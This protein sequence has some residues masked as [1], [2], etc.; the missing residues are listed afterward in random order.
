M[1]KYQHIL[2]LIFLGAKAIIKRVSIV[3]VA[4]ECPEGKLVC[5]ESFSP[6]ITKL[7]LSKNAAGLGMAN[8]F[9]R[10]FEKIAE[11]IRDVNNDCQNL[12]Q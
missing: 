4:I 9:F 11:K 2:K 8:N 3:N 1:K 7:E 5:P 10:K 6:I 12:G